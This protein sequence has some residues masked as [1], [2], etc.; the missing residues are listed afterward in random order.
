MSQEDF[1]IEQLASYLHLLPK[2]VARMADRGKLPGRKVAGKWRFSR[3]EI[4]HWLEETIGAAEEDDQLARVEGVL[5]RATGP[6]TETISLPELLSPAA[7]AVPLA[8]RTRDSVITQMVQLASSTGMLWDAEKM[9]AAV[10]AREEMHPTALACGV[11]LLHP[12]RPMP[13]ILSNALVAMGRTL[14]GIPFGGSGGQLTDIFFL[15]CS[16]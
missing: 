12:R 5:Q 7:M 15:I 3:A 6:A 10:R 14:Q 2:Q 8:A 4:H 9:I 11:A 13:A 16:D 1:D